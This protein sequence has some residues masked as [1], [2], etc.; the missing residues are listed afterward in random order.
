M[1]LIKKICGTENLCSWKEL[2]WTCKYTIIVHT[3]ILYNL[4]KLLHVSNISDHI[5][6]ESFGVTNVTDKVLSFI[7]HCHS[8]MEIYLQYHSYNT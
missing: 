3:L 4:I 2:A 1:P 6:E 7:I 5:Q 8:N